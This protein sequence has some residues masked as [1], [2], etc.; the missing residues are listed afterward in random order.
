MHLITRANHPCLPA[1]RRAC[2]FTLLELLVALSIFAVLTTMAYGGLRSVL[3]TR[4]V[5]QRQATQLAQIQMAFTFMERD[6]EQAVDRPVRDAY[7][8]APTKS[9]PLQG[10]EKGTPLLELTRAGWRNPSGA[11]RSNLQRIA[12]QVKDKRLL[13][14]S[15]NVLDQA[16]DSAPQETVLLEN[17]KAAEL[18]FFDKKLAAQRHWPVD[19][20][21]AVPPPQNA[22]QPP[23]RMPRAIEI[24]VDIDGW[25]R[26]TRLFRSAGGLL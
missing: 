20:L 16:P 3:D 15:W 23:Q 10:V 21:T 19:N 12:Y 25:G 6:I 9:K 8:S 14:L 2:G 13:R 22:G 1:R 17:V 11:P 7:G 5:S 26:I 18:R 4:A 24:S